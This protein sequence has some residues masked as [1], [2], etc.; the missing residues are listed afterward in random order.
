MQITGSGIYS[1]QYILSGKLQETSRDTENN[2][3][4]TS[5]KEISKVDNLK[6]DQ[7]TEQSMLSL[8][9]SN[10]DQ[11]INLDTLFSIKKGKI[12]LDDVPLLLPTEHNISALSKY[13]EDQ[14]KALLKEHNIPQPP[15]SIEFDGEGN[16]VMEADYPYKSELKKA[17]DE[18]PEIENALSTTASLASHFEGI[19]EGAAF[20]EEWTTTRNLADQDRVIQKYNYLFDDNRP[21]PQ[22]SFSFLEDGSMLVGRK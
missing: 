18:H 20:R 6:N 16:L 2:V 5:S 15:A 4:F 17:F 1:N 12:N 21:A 9:T 7:S 19:R 10:G 3:T 11:K 14:F 22:I 8:D 13:S